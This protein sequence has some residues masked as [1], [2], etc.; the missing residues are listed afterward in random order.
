MIVDETLRHIG[1]LEQ[2]M[3]MIAILFIGD[4]RRAGIPAVIIS[5]RRSPA[6]NSSADVGGALRSRHLDGAAID[7]S[8]VWQGRHLPRE[9]IPAWWWESVGSY[10]ERTFGL[11]WGGRFTTRDV[12]HFD[13][14]AA[15]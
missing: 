8:I 11:R 9:Q 10:A 13:L 4:L 15:V 3:A 5:G 1:E 2:T 7:I 6:V 12:N 14:G